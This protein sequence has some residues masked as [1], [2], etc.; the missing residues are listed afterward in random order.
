MLE[1]M[2]LKD[3]FDGLTG[4]SPVKPFECVGTADEVCFAL[5]KTVE[6]YKKTGK[7]LPALLDYYD[8]S[9]KAVSR[10]VLKEFNPENNIP[11]EFA[12]KITEMYKYVSRDY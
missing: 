12:H 1:D 7:A 3:D 6:K 9:G 8:K 11:A 5:T 4:I 2:S 10:N